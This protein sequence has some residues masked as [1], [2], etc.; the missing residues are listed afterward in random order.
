MGI[1]V[2]R[3]VLHKEMLRKWKGD[4]FVVV[5]LDAKGLCQFKDIPQSK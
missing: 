2:K 3:D 4:F 1:E 5:V